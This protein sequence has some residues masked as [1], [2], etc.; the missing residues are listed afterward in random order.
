MRKA[1]LVLL[2]AILLAVCSAQQAEHSTITVAGCLMN[3]NGSFKLLT[4]DRTYILKGHH[5][6]MFSHNGKLMEVTGTVSTHDMSFPGIP[7]ELHITS[8]KTLA[9]SCH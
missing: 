8:L 4:H 1:S 3:L 5:N 2:I 9:D 7:V 6:E